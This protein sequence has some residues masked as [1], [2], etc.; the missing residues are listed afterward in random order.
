MRAVLAA[1]GLLCAGLLAGCGFTPLYAT[2][3]VTPNLAAVEVVT[4][5]GRTGH[6][7]SEELKDDLAVDGRP[8]RYRLNLAV[9]ETRYARGLSTEEVATWYELSVRVNYSLVEIATGKTVTAGVVPVSISYGAVSDPY[10]GIV[11]QQDGQ[12]RA[13]GE[14][15]QR[16][17]LELG[18]YFAEHN[19][20]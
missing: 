8:A 1:A 10:G 7:L 18:R 9:D 19:A 17:R 15:A 6:I 20:G 14:A 12:Q 3:G 11:A 16:L 4:P 2:P 5:D 13:A